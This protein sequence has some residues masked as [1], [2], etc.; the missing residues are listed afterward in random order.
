MYP[1]CYYDIYVTQLCAMAASMILKSVL[2]S[3]WVGSITL[4]SYY[5][6]SSLVQ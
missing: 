3:A 6:Y 1:R 4:V 2:I 5:Y